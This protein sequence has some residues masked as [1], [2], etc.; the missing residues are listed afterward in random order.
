MSSTIPDAVD[1]IL[2]SSPGSALDTLRRRRPVTHEN[3]QASYLALFHPDDLADAGLTERFAVAVFAASLHGSQAAAEFYGRGLA[4]A[5]ADPG[6]RA[7][8]R[9]AAASGAAQGPY[10][11]YREP[12]LR[13]EDREGPRWTAAPAVREALGLRLAAALEHAHLL[14][15]RPRESSPA[16]LEALVDAGWSTTGIVTLS[17]LVAFLSYQLRVIAGLRLLT[18]TPAGEAVLAA[19]AALAEAQTVRIES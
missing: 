5:G 17:Q 19:D 15:F 3:T 12:G 9:E 16:A 2:G 7:A 6:L 10:G 14:V 8:L 13:N 18:D 11:K 4:A 1:T